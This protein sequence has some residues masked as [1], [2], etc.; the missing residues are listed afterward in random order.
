MKIKPITEHIQKTLAINPAGHSA[1]ISENRFTSFGYALAGLLHMLRYAKN[2]R[3]Q[4]LAAGVVLMVGLWL[5][6][7][8]LEWAV[9]TLVIGMNMLAEFLNAAIE[10]TVNLATTDYHPM[11]QLAK[12]IGAGAVLLTT[13][14]ALIIAGLL[15]APPLYTRLL[16]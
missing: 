12:D 10:A 2:V 13:L 7:G 5:G 6:L 8:A 1:K 16:G 4:L 9:L 15:L 14:V 3:I 11:A